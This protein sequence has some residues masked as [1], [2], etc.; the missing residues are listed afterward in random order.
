[1]AK[2]NNPSGDSSVNAQLKRFGEY[3]EDLRRKKRMSLGELSEELRKHGA[4]KHGTSRQHLGALERGEVSNPSPQL[5][6]ALLKAL[7]AMATEFWLTAG[8]V[9]PAP[10]TK[11]MAQPDDESDHG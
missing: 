2:T 3:L 4:P 11:A 1:M 7:E 10:G 9:P 5:L 8:H 6:E